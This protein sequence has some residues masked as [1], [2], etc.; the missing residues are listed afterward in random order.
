MW[1]STETS[2]SKWIAN[3]KELLHF[4]LFL[5]WEKRNVTKACRMVANKVSFHV[6]EI[7]TLNADLY[8]WKGVQV[9][10]NFKKKKREN[11]IALNCYPKCG[12]RRPRRCVKKVPFPAFFC[13]WITTCLTRVAPPGIRHSSIWYK[14]H[15]SQSKF[16]TRMY[17]ITHLTAHNWQKSKKYIPYMSL[18]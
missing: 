6:F 8:C 9:N 15:E 10:K 14:S 1:P 3:I 17:R 4:L 16:I 2:L 12:P 7:H 5:L 11:K 18:P 13:S